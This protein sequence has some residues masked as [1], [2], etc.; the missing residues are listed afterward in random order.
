MIPKLIALTI[1]LSSEALAMRSRLHGEQ[2]M[3]ANVLEEP[4]PVSLAETK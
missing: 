4:T 1:A 3:K 2:Q